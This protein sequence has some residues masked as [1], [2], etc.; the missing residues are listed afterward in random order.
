[1]LNGARCLFAALRCHRL[2]QAGTNSLVTRVLDAEERV[3]ELEQRYAKLEA[4]H[5][6]L[7]KTKTVAMLTISARDHKIA[8]LQAKLAA[9]GD[10]Q[11]LEVE[12]S[13]PGS[14]MFSDPPP[15]ARPRQTPL[16]PAVFSAR[17]QIRNL[18]TPSP[19]CSLCTPSPT[20]LD[21]GG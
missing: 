17:K 11:Q 15:P 3:A 12:V 4:D 6:S 8:V 5:S 21:D 16:Q 19:S 2:P 1:M 18:S 14:A 20:P 7:V 13:T 9:A 10:V